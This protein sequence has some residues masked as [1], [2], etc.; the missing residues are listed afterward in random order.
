MLGV[1]IE[2][3]ALLD[4]DATSRIET[5]ES[6]PVEVGDIAAYLRARGV[7]APAIDVES[8]VSP[9]EPKQLEGKA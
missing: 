9:T 3:K 7:A 6:K 2:K 8:T 1:C 5:V 4:G